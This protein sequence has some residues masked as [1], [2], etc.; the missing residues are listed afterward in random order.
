MGMESYILGSLMAIVG[1]FLK[2]TMDDLKKVKEVAYEAKSDLQLLKNDHINKYEHLT[3][4]F[5]ALNDS[6]RD[7]IK[8]I[9]ELNKEFKKKD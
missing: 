1:Y 2:T 9:K 6:V 4:K 8:E 7:L 5:D 3:E